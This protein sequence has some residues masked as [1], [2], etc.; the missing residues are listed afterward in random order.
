MWSRLWFR[1]T[2]PVALLLELPGM[3]VV[4]IRPDTTSISLS[5]VKRLEVAFIGS[6][7]IEHP[8]PS[9]EDHFQFDVAVRWSSQSP[10]ELPEPGSRV[11]ALIHPQIGHG[12][13]PL[14]AIDNAAS[15]HFHQ[16]G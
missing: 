5:I 4:V 6:I 10:K 9:I 14:V 16:N 11:I 2:S 7:A 13:D 12:Y 8:C 3:H 15:V 1:P